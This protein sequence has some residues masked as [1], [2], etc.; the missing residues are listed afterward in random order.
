MAI[1]KKSL[2]DI[3]AERDR[4]QAELDDLVSALWEFAFMIMTTE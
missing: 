3:D 1:L 2:F 4:L